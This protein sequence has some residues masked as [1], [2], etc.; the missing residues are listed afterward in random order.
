M[1]LVDY[2]S[3]RLSQRNLH[4]RKLVRQSV[5]NKGN[6]LPSGIAVTSLQPVAVIPSAASKEKSKEPDDIGK[7]TKKLPKIECESSN[8]KLRTIQYNSDGFTHTFRLCDD[9]FDE[10]IK[11]VKFVRS[12]NNDMHPILD[13]R[14]AWG[15]VKQLFESQ[16]HGTSFF[17]H[18]SFHF[19]SL[20]MATLVFLFGNFFSGAALLIYLLLLRYRL[21]Q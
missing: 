20:L 9:D 7:K 8:V 15:L 6:S 12:N 16:S 14:V 5:K 21:P 19:F 2:W 11:Y 1:E 3:K 17:L 13:T 18:P 4:Q 10:F